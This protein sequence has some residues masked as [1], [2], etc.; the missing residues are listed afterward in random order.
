[1]LIEYFVYE[2]IKVLKTLMVCCLRRL[3]FMVVGFP[4]NNNY[5]PRWLTGWCFG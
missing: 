2:T 3:M 5:L 1:M 4:A